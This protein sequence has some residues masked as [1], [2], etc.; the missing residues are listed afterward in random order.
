MAGTVQ[1]NL[2]VYNPQINAGM[3]E[4]AMQQSEAFNAASNGALAFT[5]GSKKGN[6]EYEA[7]FTDIPDLVVDRDPTSSSTVNSKAL[8]QAELIKVKLNRRVGPVDI[9]PQDFNKMGL[10]Q[11]AGQFALGQMAAKRILDDQLN[12]LI[13]GVDAAIA[14]QSA[15]TYD[16][17][18]KVDKTATVKNLTRGLELF[19][20]RSNDIVCWVMHSGAFYDLMRKEIDNKSFQNG[21]I[22]PIY[23][24]TFGTLN[25]PV[26]V[27]DSPALFDPVGSVSTN[28]RK[29][30][31][32]GLTRQAAQLEMTEGM[33]STLEGPRTNR[34]N[35]VYTY[36]AEYAYNIGMRGMAWNVSAGGISP[37]ATAIGLSSNWVK[38]ATSDKSLPGVRIYVEAA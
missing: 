30:T 20:D 13:L 5:V 36:Q 1:S 35:L 9:Y 4:I 3:Y 2:V 12:T 15:L 18:T 34:A 28:V 31:I 37:D 22:T 17:T 25:R 33:L 8:A 16:A 29:Y 32:L 27:T 10:A 19:G 21:T 23:N 11:A 6:Y 24:A 38:K 26:V 14:G 7:F